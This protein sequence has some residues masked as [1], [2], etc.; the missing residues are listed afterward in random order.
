M[1]LIITTG[2]FMLCTICSYG[3]Q[4]S[5]AQ[6]RLN[7]K[8]SENKNTIKGS[9][10]PVSADYFITSKD[11]TKL[12]IQEYGKGDPVILLAGGPGLNA[13]YLQP[14]W[15]NLS[16]DYRCI[17]LNQR[18]TDQSLVAVVDSTSMTMDN[19]VNDL[20]AL[21][22]HLNLEKLVLIGH[23]WGGM[24][25]MVYLAK[26][27]ENVKKVL[28]L[29]SGGPSESFTK[30]F[31]ANLNKRLTKDDLAEI[32]KLDSLG[33]ETSRAQWPGYFYDRGRALAT[34]S[35]IPANPYGQ[36]GVFKFTAANYFA[37]SD[38]MISA[39]KKATGV[40]VFLIQGKQDPMGEPTAMDIKKVLP[41]T[42]IHYIEKC[43]HFPWLENKEQVNDFFSSVRKALNQ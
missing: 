43:G 40:P 31:D 38:A 24:L 39:L 18:G 19:Y 13:G 37:N 25:S 17:V 23:S 2:A 15:E 9:P 35:S 34:R 10:R 6:D 11:G 26:Q 8:T 36:K 21:R 42:N 30:T 3:Q 22:H 20:E 7:G 5:A 28:L 1:K 41:Q 4:P 29:D 33:L 27:P 16:K 14:V 12:H 32:K